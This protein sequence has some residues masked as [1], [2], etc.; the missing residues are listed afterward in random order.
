MNI[1]HLKLI[2]SKQWLNGHMMSKAYFVYG[3]MSPHLWHFTTSI[4]TM[5]QWLAIATTK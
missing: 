1:K 4:A 5:L 2:M 3:N